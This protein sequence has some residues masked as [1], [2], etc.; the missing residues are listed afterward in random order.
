MS[1]TRRQFGLTLGGASLALAMPSLSFAAGGA[2]ERIRKAGTI[3]VGTEAAYPPFEFVDDAGN[4]V[5]YGKDILNVVVSELGVKLNQLDTP[6]QGILPGLLAGNFDLVATSV[7]INEARAK[8]YAFTA[9][10]ANGQPYI[11]MRKGEGVKS[12]TG[13]AGKIVGTQIG[14][15]PEPV[16]QALNKKL[17]AAGKGFKDLKLYTAFTDC[18]TA[19]ASGEIDAIIQSLPGLTVVVKEHDDVFELAAPV[20]VP[21]KWHYLAWCVRPDETDLRDFINSVIFK[22]RDDGRL[23]K[24][25]EKWFGFKMDIPESDYLPPDAI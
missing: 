4:I 5:G 22:M 11:M 10:I 3:T 20:E 7:S 8:K 21:Y 9:P 12:E 14:S 25:Q 15:A 19:L 16:A 1:M 17:K 23:G 24:L 18:Y 6:F 13:L 2:V